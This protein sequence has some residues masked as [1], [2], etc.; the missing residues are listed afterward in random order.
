[1]RR[2]NHKPTRKCL[3]VRK[4]VVLRHRASAQDLANK[5]LT[6]RAL[7]LTPRAAL[8]TRDERRGCPINKNGS[9]NVPGKINAHHM[10]YGRV[11]W[12]E[13]HSVRHGKININNWYIN[14]W[15]VVRLDLLNNKLPFY[16]YPERV[17]KSELLTAEEILWAHG[18]R[19]CLEGMDQVRCFNMENLLTWR[20]ANSRT[21]I[22]RWMVGKSEKST[23][24]PEKSAYLSRFLEFFLSFH[25]W[26]FKGSMTN[27]SARGW[28]P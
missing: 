17:W 1:M 4:K 26:T 12:G 9:A 7:S 8:H 25:I 21:I 19:N 15:R 2:Q 3:F 16:V 14:N 10:C 6:S 5:H 13:E 22:T 11:S 24:S 20:P 28:E 23:H 18:P 27:F